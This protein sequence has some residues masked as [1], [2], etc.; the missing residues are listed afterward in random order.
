MIPLQN[1]EP[2][3]KCQP[4][5]SLLQRIQK[6]LLFYLPDCLINKLISPYVA[7]E[8]IKKLQKDLDKYPENIKNKAFYMFYQKSLGI[9]KKK[10]E[11]SVL[12]SNMIFSTKPKLEKYLKNIS[13][14]SNSFPKKEKLITKIIDIFNMLNDKDKATEIT[15]NYLSDVSLKITCLLLMEID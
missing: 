3:K 11:Q 9:L 7:T 12:S 10:L 4:Q 6:N 8:N 13:C 14:I 1:I 2:H 15:H 5:Y